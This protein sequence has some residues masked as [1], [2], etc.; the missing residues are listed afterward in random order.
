MDNSLLA[1]RDINH[2]YIVVEKK[3]NKGSAI[4][5]IRG[6]EGKIKKINFNDDLYDAEGLVE[7]KVYCKEGDICHDLKSSND[8]LGH[9]ITQADNAEMAIKIAEAVLSKIEIIIE[10]V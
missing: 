10:K 4:R 8:R 2:K 7:L 9:I 1:V 3:L 5:F 6:T